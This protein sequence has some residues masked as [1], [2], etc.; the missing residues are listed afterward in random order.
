[1]HSSFLGQIK[2]NWPYADEACHY[3]DVE[4]GCTRLTPLFENHI[5]DLNNWTLDEKVIKTF[6]QIEGLVPISR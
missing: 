1:M 2:V 3:W 4:A 6:P 5:S